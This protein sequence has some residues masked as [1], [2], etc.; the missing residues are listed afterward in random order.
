ML[1]AFVEEVEYF[2]QASRENSE[3]GGLSSTDDVPR[4]KLSVREELGTIRKAL[5]WDFA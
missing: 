2:L 1:S 5:W 3:V 4:K